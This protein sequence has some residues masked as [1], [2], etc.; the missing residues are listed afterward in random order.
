LLAIWFQSHQTTVSFNN[1]E[2]FEILS[3]QDQMEMYED[4]DFYAWLA[5]SD[6]AS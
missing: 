1:P 2:D 3:S 6:S 5:A 4:L